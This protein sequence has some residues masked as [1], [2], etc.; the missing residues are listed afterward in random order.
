[1]LPPSTD[2]TRS[3]RSCA[4]ST[5]SGSKG[6]DAGKKDGAAKAGSGP[7]PR[8]SRSR[9]PT[10]EKDKDALAVKDGDGDE[11][12]GVAGQTAILL[13][14]SSLQSQ[15][16]L[17][18]AF[19]A[20]L[21]TWLCPAQAAVC[22]SALAAGG[23]YDKKV[24]EAGAGHGLGSPH[25]HI[26]I[27]VV[28]ALGAED[29]LKQPDRDFWK[30]V[31]KALTV[32]P[33]DY[34]ALAFPHFRIKLTRGKGGGKGMEVE[35]DVCKISMAIDPLHPHEIEGINHTSTELACTIKKQFDAAIVTLGGERKA[36]QAPRGQLERLMETRLRRLQNR[37]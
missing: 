22:V 24:K 7:P 16:L 34:T 5:G 10:R 1:M 20:L 3:A 4:T 36:G 23:D 17:R 13:L 27:A 2:T 28:A 19:A 6:K 11:A 21:D 37:S 31:H 15:Q 30:L 32:K 33:Q 35:S 29:K 14:K 25:T 12:G 18:Q 9:G 26:F 8:R